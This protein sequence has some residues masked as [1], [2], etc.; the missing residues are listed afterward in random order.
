MKIYITAARRYITFLKG[1]IVAHTLSIPPKS[2]TFTELL[3]CYFLRS[4]VAAQRASHSS[5][6]KR[7]LIDS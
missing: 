7:A 3:S 6:N 4:S 5:R 2:R 1:L